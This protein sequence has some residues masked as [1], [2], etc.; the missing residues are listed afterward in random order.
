MS[1]GTTLGGALSRLRRRVAGDEQG[2][3]KYECRR[4]GH[5]L[6]T[7]GP[8]PACGADDVATYEL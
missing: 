6:V 8:C 7:A 2:Q 5:K 1:D 4:C 3:R